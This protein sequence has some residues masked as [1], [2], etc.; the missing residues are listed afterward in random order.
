MKNDFTCKREF[1]NPKNKTEQPMYSTKQTKT[2]SKIQRAVHNKTK[3]AQQ[4]KPI[5]NYQTQ[6]QTVNT[7]H[8]LTKIQTVNTKPNYQLSTQTLNTKQNILT[9]Y[10]HSNYPNTK[11]KLTKTQTVN[12]TFY[13]QTNDQLSKIQTIN[14]N[15]L[16]KF[17]TKNGKKPTDI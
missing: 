17:Q 11:H 2:I 6:A 15:R 13:T 16:S 14:S 1:N 10:I 5:I 7:K 12:T 4:D 9:E 8:K 3:C